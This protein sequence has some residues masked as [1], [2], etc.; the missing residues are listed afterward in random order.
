MLLK[1]SF[2]GRNVNLP[3]FEISKA[4][5]KSA[6]EACDK[7]RVNKQDVSIKLPNLPTHILFIRNLFVQQSNSDTTPSTPES[8]SSP[9]RPG[10]VLSAL[11]W[12]LEA[13]SSEVSIY[14]RRCP[15]LPGILTKYALR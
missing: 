12:K 11:I 10:H 4:F 5:I 3:T 8:A 1:Y 14:T 2:E 9:L 13:H 6:L 7:F 15:L